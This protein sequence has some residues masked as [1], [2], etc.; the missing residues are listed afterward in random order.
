[1]F[2]GGKLFGNIDNSYLDTEVISRSEN[3][4]YLGLSFK[5]GKTL[6]VDFSSSLRKFYA[7]ANSICSHSKYA[8]EITKL[9]LVE[10]YCLSLIYYGC[11]TL[12]LNSYQTHQLN[13]CWNNAYGRIFFITA[14]GSRLR[15]CSFIVAD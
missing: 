1:M 2:A 15:T 9:F 13:V 10:S 12:N 11:E 4:K 14:V 7:A 8:S 3:L 6:I 5:A